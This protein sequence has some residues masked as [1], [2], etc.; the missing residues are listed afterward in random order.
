MKPSVT[1]DED[2]TSHIKIRERAARM[3]IAL[4]LVSFLG[5]SMMGWRGVLLALIGYFF[6]G[7]L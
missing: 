1:I 2:G 3:W 7:L 6:G 4:V 5:Y